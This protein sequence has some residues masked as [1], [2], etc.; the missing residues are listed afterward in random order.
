VFAPCRPPSEPNSGTSRSCS[1]SS[2]SDVHKSSTIT[3]LL[4][5]LALP[6]VH[7]PRLHP[8]HLLHHP[9]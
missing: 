7:H 1:V 4:L 8:R 9:I 2:S 3:R 6:M 5:A